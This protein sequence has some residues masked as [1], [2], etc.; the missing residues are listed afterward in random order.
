[1]AACHKNLMHIIS[2]IPLCRISFSCEN[3]CLEDIT[4][5]AKLFVTLPNIGKEF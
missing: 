1:M 2:E 5:S 4:M 3:R